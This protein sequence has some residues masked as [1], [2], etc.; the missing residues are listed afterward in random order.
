[1]AGHSGTTGE[2]RLRSLARKARGL[3]RFSTCLVPSM[4]HQQNLIMVVSAESR[5]G[6]AS[7]RNNITRGLSQKGF[8][9]TQ[10]HLTAA[11]A[12]LVVT[13]SWGDWFFERAQRLGVKT[14]LRV[15]GFHYPDWYDNPTEGPDSAEWQLTPA[16]MAGNYRLQRDL[17]FA[18]HVVYQSSYCKAMADRYLYHRRSDYSLVLNG[19]D[20]S[21]F[22]PLRERDRTGD[23]LEMAVVMGM[24]RTKYVV[25]SAVTC[26]REV[27]RETNARLKFI[28]SIRWHAEAALQQQLVRHPWLGDHIVTLGDASYQDLPSCL[29]HVDLLINPRPRDSCPHVVCEV[30]ACGIPVVCPSTGGTPEI[31][32]EA[33]AIVDWSLEDRDWEEL[34]R[35]LAKGALE[36]ASR[37]GELSH[38]ARERAETALSSAQMTDGYLAAMGLSDHTHSEENPIIPSVSIRN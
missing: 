22:R 11:S 3:Y 8:G 32:G 10:W 37:I 35:R 25:E 33:G 23:Y 14:V 12:A 29:D 5:G 31:V 13:N 34:G 6:P 28:G 16:L 2:S 7:F 17:A 21:H 20:L 4:G 9:L 24:I 1:M 30:L 19:I 36:A 26:L 18:D 15:N 38:L 27:L